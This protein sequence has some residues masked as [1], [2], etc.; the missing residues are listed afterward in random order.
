MHTSTGKVRL[1]E[2]MLQYIIVSLYLK[3]KREINSKETEEIALCYSCLEKL[4]E[5]TQ[6]KPVFVDL[7]NLKC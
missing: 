6:H 1:T 2:I 7:R 5:N 4:N 3:I